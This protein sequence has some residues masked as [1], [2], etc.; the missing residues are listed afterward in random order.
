MES[1]KSQPNV[2]ETTLAV[3]VPLTDQYGNTKNG[4]V[5]RVTL[6]REALDKINFEG[7]SVNNLSAIAGDYW[8][9]P[10][11]FTK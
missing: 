10:A 1:M 8:E 4:E 2:A 9:H 5:L 6:S 3:Q 7:F 11:L